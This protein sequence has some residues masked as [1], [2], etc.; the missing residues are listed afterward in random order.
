M[1]WA[2]K[3]RPPTFDELVGGAKSLDHLAGNMQHLLLHSREAGTGKTTLAHVL[4]N[5]LDYPL[6]VFNASSKKTRGIAFVEEDL[7]PLTRAGNYKQ[8]ILLDEADQLTPAAQSALK[9]VIE[10]SQGFFILTCNDLSK[11][12][13]WIKSRCLT[14]H[15]S[16]IELESMMQ[17]LEYICGAEGVN[18][19]ES[20][21]R[22]ICEAHDGDLRNAINALQAFAS[23]DEPVRATQFIQT[24][25]VPDFDSKGF[26]KA[27]LREKDLHE[28]LPMLEGRN[29][30]EVVRTSFTWAFDNLKGTDLKL[31]IVDAAITA[32]RDILNGV[33]EDII[34][35][36]FVRM[37]IA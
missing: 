13:A 26:L 34:K 2:N 32:E 1:L 11:V 24:L 18:I 29:T 20:Q 8:I 27:C 12:S 19:T 14:I 28:A 7:I 15:F 17:R 3:H 10:N 22:I 30:R 23:F 21:L 4:A 25:A 36:N 33:D 16:P 31:Q 9:G 5:T 6:H 35:A 37:L